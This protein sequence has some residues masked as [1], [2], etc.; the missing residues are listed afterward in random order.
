M[1]AK[2]EYVIRQRT[3][4]CHYFVDGIRDG[5]PSFEAKVRYALRYPTVEAAWRVVRQIE[6]PQAV[7]PMD[8]V[9]AEPVRKS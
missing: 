4:F 7:N 6:N 5:K 2:V 9:R 3:G 8:V 1:C